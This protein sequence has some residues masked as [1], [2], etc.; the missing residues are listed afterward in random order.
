MSS[1]SHV[2]TVLVPCHHGCPRFQTVLPNVYAIGD[3]IQGPMLAHKAEDEAIICCEVFIVFIVIVI[4]VITVI[5]VIVYILITV[6]VYILITVIV[7]IVTVFIT[8]IITT[9]ICITAIITT[10]LALL[11]LRWEHAQGPRP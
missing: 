1:I 5:T 9:I 7:I 4:T 8:I 6:I 10:T 2:V 11:S 3:C